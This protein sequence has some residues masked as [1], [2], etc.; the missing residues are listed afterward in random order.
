MSQNY[1]IASCLFTARFPQTSLR[2]Q[3]Y[4]QSR[5]EIQ[6][7]RCCLPN[8]R[9]KENTDRIPD[10]RARER[11]S[12]TTPFTEY[13]SGDTVYSLCHNCTNILEEQNEGLCLKSLWEL[14]DSDPDFPFPDYSGLKVTLQDCWRSRERIEEQNAVRSLLKKMR[15]SF[16]ETAENRSKTEFCGSTLYRPQPE[17]NARFAP[18]HY[19][20]QATGKFLPHTE[21]EQI[22]IMREHCA[23]YTTDTVICYCHYCLEGL[24]QGGVDGRH[25]AHLLFPEN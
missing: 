3:D 19:I 22:A 16:V 15:I 1:Y 20:E 9:V 10:E 8:F 21:E 7:V 23:Q 18:K 6:T 14:I 13:A 24:Q 25:I 17:K 4:I 5:G 11:W 2:I 12:Q